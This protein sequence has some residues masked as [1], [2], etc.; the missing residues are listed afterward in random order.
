MPHIDNPDV[1]TLMM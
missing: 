1:S